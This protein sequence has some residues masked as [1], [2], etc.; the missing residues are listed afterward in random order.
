MAPRKKKIKKLKA[1]SKKTHQSEDEVN[2]FE[3]QGVLDEEIDQPQNQTIADCSK[4]TESFRDHPI[5]II[6]SPG[7]GEEFG[8]KINDEA[9][10]VT[11]KDIEERIDPKYHR[12]QD[13]LNEM[14]VPVQQFILY[15]PPS[16]LTE[17]GISDS[18]SEDDDLLTCYTRAGHLVLLN[19]K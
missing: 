16:D 5:T 9:I 7:A 2:D 4:I 3:H 11:K 13:L 19:L 15:Q 12:Y 10:R 14:V 6:Y 1:T 8:T 17:N 18:E